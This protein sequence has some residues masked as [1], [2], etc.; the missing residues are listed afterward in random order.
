MRQDILWQKEYV[1]Y[2]YIDGLDREITLT[3]TITSDNRLE[4]VD[5]YH[6]VSQDIKLSKKAAENMIEGNVSPFNHIEMY[7]HNAKT[8]R[9][10]S[11]RK[12]IWKKD[13]YEITKNKTSVRL[14]VFDETGE[15]ITG[16]GIDKGSC[17][18]IMDGVV[19]PSYY[20]E[21]GMKNG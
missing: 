14:R 21:R 18:M 19:H 9:K 17:A 13:N 10:T 11:D 3:V 8:Q 15:L 4:W 5:D 6:N 7:K 20:I 2:K 16:I 12:I 1:Y